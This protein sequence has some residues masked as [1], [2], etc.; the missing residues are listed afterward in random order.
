MDEQEKQKMWMCI[1]TLSVGLGKLN[2]NFRHLC[3]V[4]EKAG[5]IK[6]TEYE[7]E[8]GADDQEPEDYDSDDTDEGGGLYGGNNSYN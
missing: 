1:Q 7:E 8:P 4:L 5:V 3:N 2:S 6:I